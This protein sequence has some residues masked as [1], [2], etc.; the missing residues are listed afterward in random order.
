MLLKGIFS[1]YNFQLPPFL[2]VSSSVRN[3]MEFYQYLKE[4]IFI[5]N[6]ILFFAGGNVIQTVAQIGSLKIFHEDVVV[7]VVVLPFMLYSFSFEKL[8]WMEFVF[9]GMLV[10]KHPRSFLVLGY[11]SSIIY[12]I[13]TF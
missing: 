3:G 12:A 2:I 5:W 6:L 11:K 7:V 13:F 4:Y 1:K 9:K 8:L 10:D